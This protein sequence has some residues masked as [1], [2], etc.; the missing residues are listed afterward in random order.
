[1]PDCRCCFRVF[2]EE[3]ATGCVILNV[4]GSA[5]SR[6]SRHVAIDLVPRR[7]AVWGTA[8]NVRAALE[9]LTARRTK[10]DTILIALS[11]H[12]LELEVPHPDDEKFEPKVYSYFCPLTPTCAARSATPP[13]RARR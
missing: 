13:A 11:G 7:R 5:R 8:A 6:R 4:T 3:F 10:H 1:M 12:G 9:E 2:R